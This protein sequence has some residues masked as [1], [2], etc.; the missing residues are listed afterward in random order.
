MFAQAQNSSLGRCNERIRQIY[1]NTTKEIV[2]NYCEND[3]LLPS[4]K[5]PQEGAKHRFNALASKSRPYKCN[6]CNIGFRFQVS[7]DFVLSLRLHCRK[8]YVFIR[9]SVQFCYKL[10]LSGPLAQAQPVERSF[11]N[12]LFQKPP[13]SNII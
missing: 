11:A 8:N 4:S 2:S 5:S 1:A 7:H 13:L 12:G 9:Y 3:L 6:V 10:L